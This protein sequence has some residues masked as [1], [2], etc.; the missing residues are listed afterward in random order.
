[1][2][3]AR[4]LLGFIRQITLDRPLE[5]KKLPIWNSFRS[6]GLQ[7]CFL[8]EIRSRRSEVGSQ[9]PEERDGKAL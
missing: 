3:F 4:F 9:R 5:A 1:Q 7:K 8:G 6:N 2:S